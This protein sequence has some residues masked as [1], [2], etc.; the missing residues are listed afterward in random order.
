M[1]HGDGRVPL[2]AQSHAQQLRQMQTR[3]RKLQVGVT[4]H[5]ISCLVAKHAQQDL[6]SSASKFTFACLLQPK[7]QQTMGISTAAVCLYMSCTV[8]HT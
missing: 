7:A 8:T 5:L 1:Q 6:S 4:Y 3:C 2:D